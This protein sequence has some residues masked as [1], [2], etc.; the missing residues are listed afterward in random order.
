MPTDSSIQYTPGSGA[1]LQ[2]VDRTVASTTVTG[3]VTL[4]GEGHLAT[5]VAVAR[6][7]R[8]NTANSHLLIV[9]GDGTNYV[10]LRRLTV[11][12]A[13]IATASTI[14]VRVLRTTTAGT[15]GSSISARSRDAADT[16]PYAGTVMSLPTSKGTESDELASLRL[17][18]AAANPITRDNRDEWQEEAAPGIKPIIVGNGTASGFCVKNIGASATE[19]DIEA[20]WSL[21]EY[22]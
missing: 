11:R 4:R 15:G 5:Y 12:Q 3:Q 14:D 6:G 22:L 21:T 2:G 17:G 16:T 18:L 7:V 1:N 13:N 19:V 8:I 9:Q 10:R 20:V